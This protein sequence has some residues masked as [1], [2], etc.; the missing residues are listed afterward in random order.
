MTVLDTVILFT[1]A[2]PA[3]SAGMMR[4]QSRALIIS[5]CVASRV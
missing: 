5:A 2:M 3:L 4:N 1:P